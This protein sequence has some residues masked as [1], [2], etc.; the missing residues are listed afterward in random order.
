MAGPVSNAPLNTFWA[1]N[2]EI[3]ALWRISQTINA[4]LDLDEVLRAII[5]EV[6][7]LLTAQSASV[8]LHDDA[9]KEAHII[10]T[11]A[12][13]GAVHSLRYPL[14]GSLTE[15]VSIHKRPLRV[16]RLTPEEWPAVWRLGVQLGAA[17]ERIS[18][19]LVPLWSRGKVMGSLEV[20]WEPYHDITDREEQLLEV[21]ASQ[22]SSAIM[23]AQ[24]YQEKDR[25]L[26]K[27][28]RVRETLQEEAAVALALVRVSRGLIASSSLPA[29]PSRLCQLVAEALASHYSTTFL[30]DSKGTGARAIANWGH[31]AERFA[32]IQTIGFPRKE[33]S[34]LLALLKKRRFVLLTADEPSHTTSFPTLVSIFRKI[35]V[36]TVLLMAIQNGNDLV[37]IQTA[38]YRFRSQLSSFQQRIVQELQPLISLALRGFRLLEEAQSASR[39]KSEFLATMSHELRTPLNIILGYAEFLREGDLGQLNAQQIEAL[40]HID[41]SARGLL[42]LVIATLDIGRLEAGRLSL[43]PEEVNVA[44]LME[45]LHPEVAIQC[46]QAGL[47]LTWRVAQALPILFT[48]RIKLKTVLRNLLVNAVKFTSEGGITVHM[49]LRD[50]GVEFCV[51]DT[52][53]GVSPEMQA[54]MFEMFRQGD[55]PTTRASK[56]V[57]LGLYIVKRF[58]DVLH[59]AISVES[60]VGKGSTFRV[61][62]P[63]TTKE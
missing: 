6:P 58:L 13:E 22:A 8:V 61:W 14:A 47:T 51:A 12:R 2:P 41:K 15:W 29:L 38:G 25:A 60:E 40:Q 7:G 52:G 53:V 20:V 50:E 62:L 63:L 10:T 48:D 19:L 56:G 3:Q 27:L 9:T 17:P 49:Q 16:A 5:L 11:Y 57:G 32:I 26:A 55:N 42:E 31:T 39:I 35:D 46:R 37:G 59:G 33:L 1:Q 18:I 23:N 34:A 30:L 43:D 28:Q 36:T 44:A 24:L 4:T 54:V 21:F 45:E